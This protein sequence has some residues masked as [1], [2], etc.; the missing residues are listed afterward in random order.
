MI[1]Q[2]DRSV[3]SKKNINYIFTIP[4]KHS[5]LLSNETLKELT[6]VK[7]NFNEYNDYDNICDTTFDKYLD[8]F[9]G[10]II[11][12]KSKNELNVK[13]QQEISII[14]KTRIYCNKTTIGCRKMCGFHFNTFTIF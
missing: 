2:S 10:V 8:K 9:N 4:F 11:N 5:K 13:Q 3:N 14:L 1:L 7:S 12:L 6:K